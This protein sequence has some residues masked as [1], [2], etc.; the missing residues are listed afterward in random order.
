[1]ENKAMFRTIGNMI[2]SDTFSVNLSIPQVQPLG[3]KKWHTHNR[4]NSQGFHKSRS[5]IILDRQLSTELVTVSQPMHSL[6][7]C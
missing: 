1:M 3:R 6:W 7:V 4:D 5:T 2:Y